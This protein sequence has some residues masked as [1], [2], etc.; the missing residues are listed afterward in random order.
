MTT[1]T[2]VDL[3]GRRLGK[4]LIEAE[5][6]HGGMGV[7][8]RAQ[9]T[10]LGRCVALKVVTEELSGDPD[11]VA[12]FRRE[13]QAIARL[14]HPG[15][16]QV[17]DIEEVDGRLFLVMEWVD[18]ESLDRWLAQPLPLGRALEIGA[19]IA[20][21]LD[22]AHEKGV[23]HRDVKPANV[24]MT[25]TGHPKVADFGLAHL[26]D[27]EKG[28][29][30]TGTLVGSPAYMSPEQ[31]LGR[32][33]DR[34]SDV[35]SLG[36]VLFRMVTGRV[37]F[38]A[39]STYAVLRM[40]IDE[41]PPDPR[42]LNTSLPG[43][44]RDAILRALSKRPEERFPTMGSFRDALRACAKGLEPSG[45]LAGNDATRALPSGASHPAAPGATEATATLS[46]ATSRAVRVRPHRAL[47]LAGLLASAVIVGVLVLGRSTVPSADGGRVAPGSS[48]ASLPPASAI[49]SESP[50]SL[51]G[52][53]ARVPPAEER[54]VGPEPT[55]VPRASPTP[56][57]LARVAPMP[58]SPAAVPAAPAASSPD[59]SAPFPDSA[60]AGGAGT[61]IRYC[62]AFGSTA[63][64]Q[65]KTRGFVPGFGTDT[66]P[67][68]RRIRP[69]SGRIQIAMRL[70]PPDPEEGRAFALTADL[71]NDGLFDVEM[72]TVEETILGS[73]TTFRTFTGFAKPTVIPAGRREPIYA[74]EG[75]LHGTSPFVKSLRV[76]DVQGDSWTRMVEIRPCE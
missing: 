42:T 7:V 73:L 54:R 3:V 51:P 13:A 29:T 68:G 10:S 24:L 18:G 6:G 16:V 43:T 34:R 33:V 11:A 38:A 41:A 48:A 39:E 65:S 46:T 61:P 21:A 40:H 15:I 55:S 8:Y 62:A 59:V 1:A 5:L 60:P 70:D 12:R 56:V 67:Q 72:A 63:F 53:A 71:V 19:E 22:A 4:Y 2:L 14:N 32:S 58:T 74:F 45:E 52:P 36:V 26:L 37:P 44:V 17:H 66:G 25:R 30:K 20:D 9:Q 69:D 75:E 57:R 47:A 50:P 23:V 28:V 35:Y 64:V 31:A 27:T 76:V 49:V